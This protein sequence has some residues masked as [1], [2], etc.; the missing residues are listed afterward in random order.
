MAWRYGRDSHLVIL[1]PK[2]PAEMVRNHILAHEVSH[3]L[4]E[5]EARA[6]GC[7]Q[8]LRTDDAHL[9]AAVQQMH[10]EVQRISRKL[11]RDEKELRNLARRLVQDGLSLLFNGPL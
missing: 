5:S 10:G 9:D 1:N 6:A 2:L 8:W 4:M 7:N 11:R 3:I